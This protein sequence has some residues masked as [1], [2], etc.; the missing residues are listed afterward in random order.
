MALAQQRLSKLNAETQAATTE[1]LERESRSLF[2]RFVPSGCYIAIAK[3]LRFCNLSP[4]VAL[5]VASG[6]GLTS[7]DRKRTEISSS[8]PIRTAPLKYPL[9]LR[10]ITAG[11]SQQSQV[12]TAIRPRQELLQFADSEKL[13]NADGRGPMRPSACLREEEAW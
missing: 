2:I 12:R 13:V 1:N 11:L 6:L 5:L 3:V 8:P 4:C 9:H 7:R 10:L